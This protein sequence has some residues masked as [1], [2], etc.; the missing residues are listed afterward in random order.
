MNRDRSDA[1]VARIGSYA[2]SLPALMRYLRKLWDAPAGYRR[3]AHFMRGPG[4][5]SRAK[6]AQKPGR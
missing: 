3:E 4:P 5:K 2:K 6:R 1:M